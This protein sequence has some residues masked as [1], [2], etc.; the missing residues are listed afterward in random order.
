MPKSSKGVRSVS[1]SES[2]VNN[3]VPLFKILSNVNCFRIFNSLIMF[4]RL[5]LK[6]IVVILNISESLAL[7]HLRKLQ[8]Y[9]LLIKL[10][11]NPEECYSINRNNK[12]VSILVK[13][14]GN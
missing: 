9:G 4:G 6:E 2:R 12:N 1:E 7:R 3:F 13:I 14:F 10:T 5:N 11:N 8:A